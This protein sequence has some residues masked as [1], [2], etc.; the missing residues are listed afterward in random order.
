MRH[1]YC[2]RWEIVLDRLETVVQVLAVLCFV[3]LSLFCSPPTGR[4]SQRSAGMDFNMDQLRREVNCPYV[5]MAPESWADP[6]TGL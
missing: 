4:V 2:S 1:Y 5:F 3:V 6:K